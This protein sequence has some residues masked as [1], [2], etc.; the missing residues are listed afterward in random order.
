MVAT[1]CRYPRR[2]HRPECF[3][4]PVLRPFHPYLVGRA[5]HERTSFLLSASPLHRPG[6]RRQFRRRELFYSSWSQARI[7]PRLEAELQSFFSSPFQL[8]HVQVAFS[9]RRHL[10]HGD[11]SNSLGLHAFRNRVREA[12]F[13]P[14]QKSEEFL[15]PPPRAEIFSSSETVLIPPNPPLSA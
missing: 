7:A 6:R 5:A 13:F 10:F 1:T 8:F 11:R 15:R 2:C 12:S 4:A 3:T 9:L 14:A